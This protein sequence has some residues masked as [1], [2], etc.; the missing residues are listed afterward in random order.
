MRTTKA[1]NKDCQHGLCKSTLQMVL[2]FFSLG[3]LG[4]TPRRQGFLY[5]WYIKEV[6]LGKPGRELEKQSR[7]E[8]MPQTLP[9][10]GKVF[11]KLALVWFFRGDV[12]CKLGSRFCLNLERSKVFMLWYLPVIGSGLP[13]KYSMWGTSIS[14]TPGSQLCRRQ[15]QLPVG[16]LPKRSTGAGIRNK[17]LH[18]SNMGMHWN[19]TRDQKGSR[20]NTVSAHDPCHPS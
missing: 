1:H 8:R 5:S 13:G 19:G 16:L 4:K 20:W 9:V 15:L 3:S 17:S 6:L 18:K 11:R 14:D 12:G 2:C 7:E 10:L